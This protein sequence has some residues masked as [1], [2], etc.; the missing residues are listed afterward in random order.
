[1]LTAAPSSRLPST[2][3][4]IS[5]RRS[6]AA[7][8]RVLREFGI[9]GKLHT[10]RHAF[11]SR[12]LTSGIEESEVRSWVGHVDDNVMKLYAHIS[13]QMSQDRVKRLVS[14]TVAEPEEQE[15]R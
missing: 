4:Q 12:C 15:L 8:K 14:P 2:D 7:F 11:I 3:R 10:I 13:S 1:M 5:E 6:L 9:E